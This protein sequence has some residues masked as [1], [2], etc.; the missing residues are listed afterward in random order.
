M[1]NGQARRWCFT[2][3]NPGAGESPDEVK[4][5]LA[6]G[7]GFNYLVFQEEQGDNGTPHYQGYVEFDGSRRFA[8]VKR[9]LQRAHWEPAMGTSASNLHYCSKPVDGCDCA[10]CASKP[11]RLRGPWIE[12]QAG[13]ERERTSTQ[14]ELKRL[15]TA[16]QQGATRHDLLNDDDLMPLLARFPRFA[17]ECY[18]LFAPPLADPPTVTLLYGPTGCGKTREVYAAH[19]DIWETPIGKGNWYDGYDGQEDVLFDDFSGKSSH[20]QLVDLL[21]VLHGYRLRVPIKGGFV[22]WR[23]RRIFITTNNHP[24]TWFDWSTREAQYPALRRRIASVVTWRADGTDRCERVGGT[25]SFEAFWATF[26][27]DANSA[28]PERQDLPMD[29]YVIRSRP[30]DANR[31]Y[32]WIYDPAYQ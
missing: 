25:R 19:P 13:D 23:P 14:E 12:G 7:K 32:D 22:W 29:G 24:W 6:G 11:V 10:H 9:M 21:R 30:G 5:A 31:R 15:R 26:E 8:A 17:D 2:L 18:R 20:M 27:I 28:P 4:A 1:S 16:I 3:N